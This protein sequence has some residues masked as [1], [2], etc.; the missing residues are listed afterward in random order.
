M[1]GPRV[2]LVIRSY[3]RLP[4]LAALVEQLLRQRHD[5]FEIVVVEQSTEED[6]HQ[7][8]DLQGGK[9]ESRRFAEDGVALTI[10]AD[11]GF[12]S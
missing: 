9:G 2:S 8:N 11:R 3:N 12:V 5:A 1:S 10:F 4:V 7:L 6:N